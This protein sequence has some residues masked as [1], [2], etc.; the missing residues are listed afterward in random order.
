MWQ[1]SRFECK[2]MVPVHQVGAV[3]QWMQLFLRP[4]SFAARR[5][6]FVYPIGSLY[7]DS[8]GLT[9]HRMTECGEKNRFKLR[10]RSYCDAPDSP[11]YFEIKRRIDRTI[12]KSRVTLSRP[13][14]Q[15]VLAG[16]A[17]AGDVADGE[18]RHHLET[19]LQLMYGIAA[20]PVARVRYMREAYESPANDRVRLTLDSTLACAGTLNHDF[21]LEG[22]L[23]RRV[24]MSGVLLEIKFT[25]C[26]PQWVAEMVRQFELRR[27][28]FSKY[29]LSVTSLRRPVQ[30]LQDRMGV[31]VP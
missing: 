18:D 19:F 12:R 6:G 28:P 21:S 20:G 29:G 23:W 25:D 31:H 16:Y 26:F 14:A 8:P 27:I 22:G 5:E 4:D 7:L 30:R 3:R 13:D 24:H 15:A 11:L 2:Y 10:I 17:R 9:L 1:T